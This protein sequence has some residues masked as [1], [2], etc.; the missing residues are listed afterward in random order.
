MDIMEPITTFATG[1]IIVQGDIGQTVLRSIAAL[2]VAF[3]AIWF[4]F[5]VALNYAAQMVLRWI[6]N[7]VPVLPTTC[8]SRETFLV[9]D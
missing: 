8:E 4:T 2:V 6:S 7:G 5:G 1:Y 9:E 3:L